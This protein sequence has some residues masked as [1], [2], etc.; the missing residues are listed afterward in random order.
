MPILALVIILLIVLSGLFSGLTIGLYSLDKTELERKSEL[1]DKDARRVYRVRQ[2]GNLLLVSLL[3]GNVAVNAAISIIL[4]DI[5]SGFIAGLIATAL[6]VVFGEIIPQAGTFRYALEIGSRTAWFVEV[7]MVLFYPVAKPIAWMLDKT[8]GEEMRTVWTK[9]ELAHIIQ[10]HEDDPRS[11]V[12]ADEE[13]ILLGALSFSDKTAG[14]IMTPES[15][16]DMVH[17]DQEITQKFLHEIRRIGYTRLPVYKKNEHDIVGLLYTKD[18]LGVEIGRPLSDFVRKDDLLRVTPI[19]KLDGLLNMMIVRHA[20]MAIV[21]TKGGVFK[22]IVTMED[23]LE[24]IIGREIED[25]ID[26]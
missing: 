15:D 14:Q 2:K 10:M 8:L 22:G 18:L 3:L 26:D 12:D 13:R 11:A 16:V 4:G 19:R 17:V 25:E 24:E 5:A 23:V 1:G 21:T 20:H 6:I 9:R 7:I